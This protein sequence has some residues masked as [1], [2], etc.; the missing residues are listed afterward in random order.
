VNRCV[1]CCDVYTVAFIPDWTQNSV[2]SSTTATI[3]SETLS[4]PN[5][6]QK[7]AHKQN[8]LKA[9]IE[10]RRSRDGDI[11]L[12]VASFQ[13]QVPALPSHLGPRSFDDLCL[14]NLQILLIIF[15]GKFA[16][17]RD[18]Q[19]AE[20]QLKMPKSDELFPP[21]NRVKGVTVLHSEE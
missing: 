13:D 19:V 17:P 11:E 2:A 4:F 8:Y 5:F 1:H 12:S 14:G 9:G 16:Q 3:K 21:L 10:W 15:R 18:S 7:L 6:G 20:L